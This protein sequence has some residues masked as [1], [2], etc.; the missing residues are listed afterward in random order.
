MTLTDTDRQLAQEELVYLAVQA[1]TSVC[2]GAVDLDGQGWSGLDT[3]FGHRVSAIPFEAWTP[4]IKAECARI[5][6]TYRGQIVGLL[7]I[8]VA[9][10][11][12]V[13]AAKEAGRSDNIFEARSQA[14]RAAR[15]V[16]VYKRTIE[17][18]GD[19]LLIRFDKRD[20]DF[21][22]LL[23]GV[24]ALP[25]RQWHPGLGAWIAPICREV[26]EFA[27]AWEYPVKGTVAKLLKEAREAPIAISY[28][29]RLHSEMGRAVISAP[30]NAARLQDSRVLPGRRWNGQDKVDEVDLCLTL[31][32]FARRWE[33]SI[34]P[35]VEEAICNPEVNLLPAMLELASSCANPAFLPPEFTALVKEAIK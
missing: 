15:M 25:K 21:T 9:E 16:E 33:L 7:G 4:E 27:Q 5:I 30:Y 1:L 6:S 12:I 31:L 8:D 19:T 3:K 18:E 10:L 26:A 13:K 28:N 34:D 24:R 32:D 35:A 29:V 20:P 14:R 2:D 22:G 11:E 23:E 17:L